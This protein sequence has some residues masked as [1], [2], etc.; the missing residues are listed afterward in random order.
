MAAA[1]LYLFVRYCCSPDGI[2][3]GLCLDTQYGR[4]IVNDKLFTGH[5]R[6]RTIPVTNTP[7]E[8]SQHYRTQLK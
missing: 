4:K 6:F 3:M 7:G 1:A 5:H 2:A 8:P